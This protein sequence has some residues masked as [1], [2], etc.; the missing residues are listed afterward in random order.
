M[1]FSQ[2]QGHAPS[3]KLVQSETIDEDLRNSLWSVLKIFYWDKYRSYFDD[4]FEPNDYVSKSNLESLVSSLWMDLFK[5]P[6]DTIPTYWGDCL[7]NLRKQ[8]FSSEWYEVYDLIESVS[9]FGPADTRDRFETSCNRILD[10]ESSAYRFVDGLISEIASE[11]EIAEV[12]T[13]LTHSQLDG[14]IQKHLRKALELMNDRSN[15]DYR[16]SIKES[17]SAVESL[18]IKLQPDN[19]GRFGSIMNELEKSGTIHPALKK[20][21]TALYGYTSDADGIRHALLTEEKLVLA[22]ARLMLVSC[23][24]FINYV[25]AKSIGGLS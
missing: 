16:N 25:I 19:S 12:E 20:S 2:R 6:L 7:V 1:K 15:P 17:I 4:D 13:A 10:R 11:D 9:R 8:Y 24:A 14:E 21:F 22:D 5:Q 23:S 3:T 18:A